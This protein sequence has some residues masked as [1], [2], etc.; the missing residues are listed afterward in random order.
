MKYNTNES[1][2]HLAE[3]YRVFFLP[4]NH[5]NVFHR[6]KEEGAANGTEI[7]LRGT[8]TRRCFYRLR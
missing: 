8:D 1:K 3:K 2:K 7:L 5:L 6:R 4:R